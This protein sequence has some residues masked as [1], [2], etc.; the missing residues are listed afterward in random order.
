MHLSVPN[1]SGTVLGGPG[2][3][4]RDACLSA[5]LAYNAAAGL[6]EKGASD[7]VLF[8]EIA[9]ARGR[10]TEGKP[11]CLTPLNFLGRAGVC[12]PTGLLARDTLIRLAKF[13]VFLPA[14]YVYGRG[15][16]PPV[17]SNQKGEFRS[18]KQCVRPGKTCD[19]RHL[20][21]CVADSWKSYS[22]STTFPKFLRWSS[23]SN[24]APASASGSMCPTMGRNCPLAIHL[25]S[26]D[27]A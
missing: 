24:A 11:I 4:E 25:E 2:T 18:T 26:C 1:P 16:F 23:N 9:P 8:F 6:N 14:W 3:T 13:P 27:H 5:R 20:M 12:R 17:S 7:R 21:W 19:S 22:V 10:Q 15:A